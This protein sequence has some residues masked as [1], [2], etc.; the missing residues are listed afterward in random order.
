[1]D[2][3][4]VAVSIGPGTR[5]SSDEVIISVG[6]NGNGIPSELH[7]RIFDMFFTTKPPGKGTGQG[8]AI[9][10]AIVRRHGGRINLWSEVGK[11]TK[12]EVCMPLCAAMP[13]CPEP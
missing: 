12:F 8:L 9:S 13:Q 4:Q 1:M 2:R 5:R 11:G 7:Q 3:P 6:D 10:N